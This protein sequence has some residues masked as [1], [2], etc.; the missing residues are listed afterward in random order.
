MELS[1]QQLIQN[2]IESLGKK[3][4]CL[5]ER[6]TLLKELYE[7]YF[8]ENRFE[9]FYR[10]RKWLGKKPRTKESVEEFKKVKL[11]IE[12]KY[13]KPITQSYFAIKLSHI[14]TKDLYYLTS[15]KRDSVNRKGYSRSSFTRWLFFNIKAK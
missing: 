6:Q 2:K 13:I 1:I 9:N 4:K 7:V 10:Y 15:I 3:E 5:N 8:L 11:P 12:Q 14:P